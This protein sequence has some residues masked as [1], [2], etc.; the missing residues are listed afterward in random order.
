M[1]KGSGIQ[2]G[3]SLPLMGTGVGCSVGLGCSAGQV[4]GTVLV[5]DGSEC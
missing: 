1:C 5:G 3:V 2:P 4:W